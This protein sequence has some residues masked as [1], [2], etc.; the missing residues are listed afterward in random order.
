MNEP[1]ASRACR[2]DDQRKDRRASGLEVSDKEREVM[3]SGRGLF[4]RPPRILRSLGGRLVVC[5]EGSESSV[6]GR[7]PGL[8]LSAATC[9]VVAGSG[10]SGRWQVIARRSLRCLPSIDK[11]G[12]ATS[13]LVAM[14]TPDRR[15]AIGAFTKS[16]RCVEPLVTELI[17]PRFVLLGGGW[18]PGAAH[19]GCI[20]DGPESISSWVCWC[21]YLDSLC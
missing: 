14:L 5:R 19:C 7:G 9:P 10:R 16:V 6:S 8:P 2:E 20:A 21:R 1:S 3:P 13:R 15:S 18:Q 12:V 11:S 17:D 4:T